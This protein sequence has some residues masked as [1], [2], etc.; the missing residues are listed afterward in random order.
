MSTQPS[1]PSRNRGSLFHNEAKQKPSQPD[2]RGECRIDGAAYDM[3]AWRRDDV[4]A[5]SLAP[6][7][8]GQKNTYPPE[9]FRGS[10]EEPAQASRG[11]RGESGEDATKPVWIGSVVGEEQ[12]YSVQAFPKQGKSGPYL[13]LFFEVVE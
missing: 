1:H 9:A 10:L 2:M 8:E 12:S 4:L 11:A 7:R 3:T 6:A 13:T 5:L